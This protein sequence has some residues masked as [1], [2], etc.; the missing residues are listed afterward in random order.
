MSRPALVAPPPAWRAGA[1]SLRDVP[2]LLRDLR[3]TRSL[4]DLRGRLGHPPAGQRMRL[5][6]ATI[7]PSGDVDAFRSMMSLFPA[8][9]SVVT[10][11]DDHGRPRGLTCSAV[12]SLSMDP[13][14]LLACVNRRN[15]SLEAIR[16][17][18]GFVVNLLRA[19]QHAVSDTFASASPNKFDGVGW[20]PSPVSGL[21]V[22]ADAAVSIDCHLHAEV[23]AGTHTI[24]IG[25]VRRSAGAEADPLVYWRRRYGTWSG[26]PTGVTTDQQPA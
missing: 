16:R 22:L 26:A 20:E 7:R 10:A 21:P 19:E 18:G 11:L 6:A 12:C 2:G 14:L 17:S 25:L 15:R 1:A 3:R 8:P 5:R 13:P 24:V 9:V 4:R 23:F